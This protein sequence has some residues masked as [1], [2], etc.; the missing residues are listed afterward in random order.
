MHLGEL[1]LIATSKLGWPTNMVL[2][3]KKD[4]LKIRFHKDHGMSP[5]EALALV[6]TLQ[7]GDI[8]QQKT[9]G[10]DRHVTIIWHEPEKPK[11]CH[12]MVL[13]LDRQNNGI[14]LRTFYR[15]SH[16]VR[17]KMKRSVCLHKRS[18]ICF[19]KDVEGDP[20]APQS[21]RSHNGQ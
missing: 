4:A 16:M 2:V 9:R 17:S 6:P 20:H 21:T 10:D 18:K 7:L 13:K 1:S 11:R 12:F 15:T 3:T 14:Y 5:N 19:F 8:Y